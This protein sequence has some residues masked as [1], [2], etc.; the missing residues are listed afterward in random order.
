MRGRAAP[1]SLHEYHTR[2]AASYAADWLQQVPWFNETLRVGFALYDSGRFGEALAAF[3]ELQQ[4]AAREEDEAGLATALLWQGHMLDLLDQRG[5]ALNRYQQ[6]ADMNLD[7][8]TRHEAYDMEYAYS[9]YAA[10][11]LQVPFEHIE[12]SLP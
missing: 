3:E 6:V 8:G 5:D 1:L 10:E 12:N 4:I 2:I 9:A 11:R 7:G